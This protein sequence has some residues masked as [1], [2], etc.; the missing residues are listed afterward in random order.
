VE[1]WRKYM[2][3]AD[4]ETSEKMLAELARFTPQS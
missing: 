1:A 2:L 4:R 3:E